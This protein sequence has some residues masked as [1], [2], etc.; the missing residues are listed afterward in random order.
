MIGTLFLIEVLVLRTTNKILNKPKPQM[1]DFIEKKKWKFS[2][3]C[4][5]TN[6]KRLKYLTSFI[7][8]TYCFFG[9]ADKMTSTFLTSKGKRDLVL[10][11]LLLEFHQQYVLLYLHHFK[12]IK[13]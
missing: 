9:L 12:S 8:N 10:H 11:L 2:L 4:L 3:N 1:T 6:K 13:T 5:K 7:R